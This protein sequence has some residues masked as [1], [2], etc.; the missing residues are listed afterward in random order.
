MLQFDHIAMSSEGLVRDR[1]RVEA[2]LGVPLQEG[3]PHEVFGTHN[4]LLGMGDLYFELIA[5]DPEAAAPRRARWFGLDGFSG[6]PRLTNWVCRTDDLEAALV[7]LGPG[8]GMPVSLARGD[9]RWRMAVPEDGMLPFGGHAPALIEWE[10]P[11]PV[12][13]FPDQG[14]RLSRLDVALPELGPLEAM[15]DDPRVVLQEGPPALRAT[16]ETPSGE[17]VL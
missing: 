5:I 15:L 6:P 17:V 9:L 1:A 16:L 11:S 4:L 8:Y 7:R 12:A 3:G 13:R 2:L 14:V 10:T